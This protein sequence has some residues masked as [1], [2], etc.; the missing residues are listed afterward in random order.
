MSDKPM[1]TLKQR[2]R[3]SSEIISLIGPGTSDTEARTLRFAAHQISRQT[4]EEVRF[5]RTSHRGR[6]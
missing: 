2:Q 6:S 1:L 3:V 4:D 5:G